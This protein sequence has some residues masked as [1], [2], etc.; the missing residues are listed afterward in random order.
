MSTES[1][2][3]MEYG[4]TAAYLRVPIG[5]L[6]SWVARGVIPHTRLSARTVRFSRADLDCWIASGRHLGQAPRG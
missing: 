3:F 1:T 6:Y 5:T 4:E 2:K